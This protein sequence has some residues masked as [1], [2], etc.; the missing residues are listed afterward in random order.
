MKSTSNDQNTC[1]S[2][3]YEYTRSQTYDFKNKKRKLVYPIKG[4]S[5]LDRKKHKK[6]MSS[7]CSGI[8]P[9]SAKESSS[10]KSYLNENDSLMRSNSSKS[11]YVK[12]KKSSAKKVHIM[13]TK[14]LGLNIEGGSRQLIQVPNSTRNN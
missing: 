10:D 12:S 5:I 11:P 4:Q 1:P 7:L 3:K 2:P 14:K 8:V 6:D 9:E 13:K